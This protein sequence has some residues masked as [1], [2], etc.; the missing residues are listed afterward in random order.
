MAPPG[1]QD[2]AKRKELLEKLH[3]K[4]AGAHKAKKDSKSKALEK[5]EKDA[6]LKA[7]KEA[8]AKEAKAGAEKAEKSKLKA[9]MEAKAAPAPAPAPGPPSPYALPGEE[10]QQIGIH[11]GISCDGCG[12]S[13]PLIG[14]A[15]KC[16]TC[17]DFDLCEKCYP[18][19][20]DLQREAVAAAAGMPGKGRHPA[21]HVFG[22]RRAGTVLSRELCDKE[23]A[24]MEEDKKNG[25][26]KPKPADAQ[27]APREAPFATPLYKSAEA[28]AAEEEEDWPYVEH[29]RPDPKFGL[30]VPNGGPRVLAPIGRSRRL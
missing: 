15:M 13:P 16:K 20:L 29:W 2:D 7:A 5:A 1:Q 22:A 14:V 25:A 9:A 4:G 11:L 6:Q 19:R 26:S 3:A 24:A 18:L 17:P 8:K 21:N 27:A 28:V 23:L 30:S 10:L 12:Q